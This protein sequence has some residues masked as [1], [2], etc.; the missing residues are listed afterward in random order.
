MK[1]VIGTCLSTDLSFGCMRTSGSVLLEPGRTADVRLENDGGQL[2]GKTGD[3]DV[4]H[5][6][7]GNVPV[8]DS[9][10][11]KIDAAAA[12][13]ASGV[14]SSV[15]LMGTNHRAHALFWSAIDD[16][17]RGV[18]ARLP[19]GGETRVT[20][21]LLV[22]PYR[23]GA[24]NDLVVPSIKR[25][26]L[27][28]GERAQIREAPGFGLFFERTGANEVVLEG[29]DDVRSVIEAAL[30]HHACITTLFAPLNRLYSLISTVTVAH[31]NAAGEY[32]RSMA[33]LASVP[34]PESPWMCGLLDKE[35]VSRCEAARLG[36][37]FDYLARGIVSKTSCHVPWRDSF[38]SRL[39][40]TAGG[41]EIHVVTVLPAQSDQ[42][43]TGG[44]DGTPKLLEIALRPAILAH[45]VFAAGDFALDNPT[46]RVVRRHWTSTRTEDLAARVSK[47]IGGPLADLAETARLVVAHVMFLR[48]FSAP[49]LSL[50]ALDA[51]DDEWIVVDPLPAAVTERLI[52]PLRETTAHYCAHPPADEANAVKS[53]ERIMKTLE[54]RV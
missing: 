20:I 44:A 4:V 35:I 49:K 51:G 6:F 23:S 7:A 37:L 33:S 50:A 32:W 19:S 8:V 48:L 39:L 16:L 10:D 52:K 25:R 26:R 42:W 31:R 27:M 11:A 1:F 5:A 22:S 45:S 46:I 21:T 13:V 9:I 40:G 2:V 53:L 41:G 30:E 38:V 54:A 14:N 29:D 43:L 3:G 24:V 28:G 47:G 36:N 18:L 34:T 12:S 17:A 15:L